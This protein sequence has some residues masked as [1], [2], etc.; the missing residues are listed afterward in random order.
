[1]FKN[2]GKTALAGIIAIS[3]S[4]S[5]CTPEMLQTGIAA[6]KAAGIEIN[7]NKQKVNTTDGTVDNK[8]AIKKEPLLMIPIMQKKL[9]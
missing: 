9:V 8:E 7:L 1:M 4:M 2:I 3:F 5:G 6:L